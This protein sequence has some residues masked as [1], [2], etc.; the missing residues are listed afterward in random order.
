MVPEY[1]DELTPPMLMREVVPQK[2][3]AQVLAGMMPA[4]SREY[5]NGVAKLVATAVSPDGQVV[6]G[7]AIPL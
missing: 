5:M 3:M 7:T 6:N 4:A 1:T 2:A